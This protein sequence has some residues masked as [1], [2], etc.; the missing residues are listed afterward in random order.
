VAQGINPKNHVQIKKGEGKKVLTNTF[1]QIAKFKNMRNA[2][3][4]SSSKVELD[5]RVITLLPKY[6]RIGFQF[7]GTAA[8]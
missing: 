3:T 6:S 1:E 7:R 2:E 4:L 5:K 8:V